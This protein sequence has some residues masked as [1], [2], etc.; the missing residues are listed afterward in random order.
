MPH[1]DFETEGSVNENENNSVASDELIII[2]YYL[3][4][5]QR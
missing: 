5:S 4:C 1:Q 3:D 2:S